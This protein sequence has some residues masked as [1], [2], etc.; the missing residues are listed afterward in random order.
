[1]RREVIVRRAAHACIALAPIYYLLPQEL[2]PFG[3][4]RWVLL[5][6]FIGGIVAFEWYRLKKG[7]TFLGLRPHEKGQ[8]ASFVW[9][10]AGITLVLW[11]PPHDIGTAALIGM[12]LTDPLAGELRNTGR[13]TR[14][15]VVLCLV[16]YFILAFLPLILMGY[17]SAT[18]SLL[19]ALV[20]S[21]VAV[22]S[23]SYKNPYLDD[24]F[25]MAVLPAGAMWAVSVPFGNP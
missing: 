14:T 3:I 13:S 2:P 25:L 4:P 10:A 21:V 16:A 1:M 12:A 23:E 9:A 22:V 15:T 24:D 19:M 20:G 6:V 18:A 11:L 5:V 17:R 7:F 8:I